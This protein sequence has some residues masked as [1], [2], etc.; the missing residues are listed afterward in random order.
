MPLPRTLEPESM[1][2]TEEVREYAEMDHSEVNRRF[3]D[4][5]VAGG[6]IGER[7]VD[8]GCGPAAIAIELCQRDPQVQVMGIDASVAMLEQA[9]LEVGFHGLYERITLEHADAK[10]L[11]GFADEMADSVISNSLLHHLAEPGPA[12]A[13]AVR[14]LAS[15]GRL[16]FRDLLRPDTDEAAE[17]LVSTYAGEETEFAQQ[18][19]RQS[20]HAALTIDEMGRL[21]GGLGIPA[22]HV[23]MTSDR[24]WTLD[25][26][27]P[28]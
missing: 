9:R 18:L 7:V 14:I 25:W 13:T 20:L 12:L 28:S 1:D 17:D 15:G 22:S 4:D 26:Q 10:G 6:P 16:F 23:Q 24:H 5:F 27:K 8:L 21:C 3:L 19:L 11:A 2:S